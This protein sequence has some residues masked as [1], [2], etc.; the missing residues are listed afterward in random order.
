MTL[1]N[2]LPDLII[3]GGAEEP[4]YEAAKDGKKATLY[5]RDNY[6]RSLLHELSHFCL[7]GDKRRKLDDFGYWYFPCG[8]TEEEQLLFE[9]VE[10]RPQGLEKAMC[11]A[12]GIKFS[13]SLDDFSGKPASESF[14]QQLEMAYQEMLISAPPTASK[15]LVALSA[16]NSY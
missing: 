15:V 6:P 16:L 2:V 10:A 12:L 14:L 13:P 11:A 7:S 4:F 1:S 8:R 9:K 5:F 3:K